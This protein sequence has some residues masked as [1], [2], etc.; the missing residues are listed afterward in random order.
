MVDYKKYIQVLDIL[1]R[2]ESI[3]SD[4]EKYATAE[5]YEE[6]ASAICELFDTQKLVEYN[7]PNWT[8]KIYDIKPTSWIL[9]N[10]CDECSTKV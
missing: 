3:N 6:K 9:F 5:T 2:K 7:K 8:T 10:N 1:K 4:T